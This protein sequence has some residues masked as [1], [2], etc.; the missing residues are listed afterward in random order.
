MR[1]AKIFWISIWLLA[2]GAAAMCDRAVA[3]HV[4]S[5][6]IESFIRTHKIFREILK[7]PG[8]YPF[9][10]VLAIVVSFFHSR[11]WRAGGML[12]LFTLVAGLNE[13]IK[14]LVG[15]A[16]PF[17]T[18]S[19][20]NIPLAPF[21]FHPFPPIGSKDLC[22]PSGHASLAFATA[23]C[24]AILLPR[25]RPLFYAR[26]DDRGPGKNFRKRALAERC[27]RGRGAWDRKRFGAWANISK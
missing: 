5:S 13:P 14:W 19:G 20:E 10:I 18:L 21:Q 27:R 22:F 7:L 24:L 2:I 12:L 8:F 23:A 9:T 15:R 26:R 17:K 16:R 3:E 1:K 11:R 25:F 6:G 4:R